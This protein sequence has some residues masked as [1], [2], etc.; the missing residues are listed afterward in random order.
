MKEKGHV[1]HRKHSLKVALRALALQR[2]VNQRNVEASSHWSNHHLKKKFSVWWHTTLAHKASTAAQAFGDAHVKRSRAQRAL[3][4]WKRSCVLSGGF[5]PH[6]DG[7][8]GTFGDGSNGARCMAVGG[9]RG[10]RGGSVGGSVQGGGRPKPTGVWRE[11][12]AALADSFRR[13]SLL[14]RTVRGFVLPFMF[15]SCV[16]QLRL[17]S[18]TC[19]FFLFF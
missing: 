8:V 7:D 12:Q 10:S 16:V 11:R 1:W 4:T 9:S 3:N 5:Q 13:A 15:Y 2:E 18:C 17:P 14:L 19:F 6:Y